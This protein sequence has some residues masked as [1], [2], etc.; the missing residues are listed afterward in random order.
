MPLTLWHSGFFTSA[1]NR[2]P[3]SFGKYKLV[4]NPK[5]NCVLPEF[6]VLNNGIIIGFRSGSFPFIFVIFE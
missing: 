3:L 1:L 5:S 4:P 2:I 6:K